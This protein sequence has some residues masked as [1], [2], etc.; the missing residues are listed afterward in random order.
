[1][2]CCIYASTNNL[3]TLNS[4]FVLNIYLICIFNFFRDVLKN[5]LGCGFILPNS[6]NYNAISTS[7]IADINFDS[8]NEIL[9]GTQGNVMIM[10]ICNYY[11][12]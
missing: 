9:L 6:G 10:K 1:M 11:I 8:Q 12:I 5:H 3:D 4:S 7:L 2:C